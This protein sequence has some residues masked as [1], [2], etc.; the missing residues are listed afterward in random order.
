MLILASL[1]S[2]EIY[3]STIS[4]FIESGILEYKT[5]ISSVP[6]GLLLLRL[7][8]TSIIDEKDKTLPIAG[9]LSR[10]S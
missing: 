9:K 10:Y 3:G 1:S 8:A 2:I 6:S 7:V 4:F 5:P